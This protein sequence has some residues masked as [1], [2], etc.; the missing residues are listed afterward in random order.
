V[1]IFLNNSPEPENPLH[2]FR[3]YEKNR[4]TSPI[5]INIYKGVIKFLKYGQFIDLNRATRSLFL[6]G[7]QNYRSFSYT[8]ATR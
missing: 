3:Q 2:V 4:A 1:F 5:H 8:V 6:P 7:V